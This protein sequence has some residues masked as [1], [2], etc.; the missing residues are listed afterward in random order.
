MEN[1]LLVFSTEVDVT[2]NDDDQTEVDIEFVKVRYF[3]ST[4]TY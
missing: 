3:V 2:E 1:D 4:F